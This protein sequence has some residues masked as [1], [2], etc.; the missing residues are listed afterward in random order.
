MNKIEILKS[1]LGD[2]IRQGR[3]E[4]YFSCPICK[5][6]T[7]KKLAV[8]LNKNSFHCWVCDYRGK[9]IR[10][11]IKGKVSTSILFEWDK[12]TGRL[13][14][15]ELDSI[16]DEDNK[17]EETIIDLPK[18]F[19]SLANKNLPKTSLAPLRYLYDRGLTK[20][21]I[22][23]WKIGYCSSGQ[24]ENRVIIPSFNLQGNCNYYIAR[25]I[26]DAWPRYLNP[27]ASKDI[28]FNELYLDWDKDVTLVEG[29]FDAVKCD[30]AIPLLG[31]TL[32]ENS[33]LFK[34]II[35]NDPT[36]YIALDPD[37]EKKARR[38]VDKFIEYDL[39][40]YKID[41][42]GYD[43]VGTMTKEEFNKRKMEAL[44]INNDWILE[45]QLLAV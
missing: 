5:H 14:V 26:V 23:K 27:E 39:E 41:V 35:F 34:K 28:C 17:I 21:D 36:L 3:E 38:L 7:K 31:S 12:L 44:P 42:R 25:S 24:Y 11:L 4:Y 20:D 43:D 13:N 18:E 16:F 10:R 37:A 32:N 8:N 9:N 2:F 6:S 30:N 45:S 15:S 40:V 33:I 1:V 19:V 29:V 22:L